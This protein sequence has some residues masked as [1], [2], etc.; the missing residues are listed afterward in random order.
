MDREIRFG[1]LDSV[2]IAGTAVFSALALVLGSASQSLGLNFPVIPYLQFDFGEVAIILAF[3]IFGPAPAVVASVVEFVGLMLFGQ[4]VPVG[5]VLKLFALV[6]TVSGLWLGSKV[7]SMMRGGGLGR[8]VGSGGVFGSAVR[9]L[10]MTVPNFYLFQFYYSPAFVQA[11]VS[12]VQPSFAA[13]G[14]Q[15]SGGNFL[16]P[17]LFFTG[18]FNVLQMALVIAISYV[19]LRVPSVSQ[20]RMAGRAPWFALVLQRSTGV[21]TERFG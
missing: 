13:I 14:I 5:P 6:S 21:P 15:I 3:F 8:L 9:A 18:I 12:Y 16:V 10:V 11:T 20:L 1:R 4:N 7:V 2:A 19:V 17:I